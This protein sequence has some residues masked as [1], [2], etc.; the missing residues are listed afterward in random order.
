MPV[1]KSVPLILIVATLLMMVFFS[2][3]LLYSKGISEEEIYILDR[4]KTF[5]IVYPKGEDEPLIDPFVASDELS[6]LILE[7]LFEGLYRVEHETGNAVQAI[8]EHVEV[9]EDGLTWTFDIY[10]DATF[11]NGDPITAK[12][13]V[14]SWLHLLESSSP[15]AQKSYLVSLFDVIKGAK[16]YR[17]GDGK[18]SDVGIHEKSK[19][20]LEVLLNNK[21]PYLSSLLTNVTF[22]AIHPDTYKQRNQNLI[23]SG[24]YTLSNLSKEEILLEKNTNYREA[25][26][27]NN[28]YVEIL[29]RDDLEAIESY[30]NKE[31]HWLLSY[32][33]P[34]LLRTRSDLH[35]SKIYATGFFY[36]SAKDGPYSD[37]R[38][39]KAISLITPWDEIRNNSGQLFPSATLIP[40][41]G[42]ILKKTKVVTTDSQEEAKRLLNL[43][44]FSSF[45]DL[46]PL[47]MA[48][49]RGAPIQ[50][51]AMSLALSWSNTLTIPVIVD[52]VPLSLYTRYPRENPYD[53]SYITWVADFNDP[54]AFLPLFGSSSSYNIANYSNKE[55][56]TLLEKAVNSNNEEERKIAIEA[57]EATLLE[58]AIIFPIHSGF[59]IHIV[60]SEVV[61]GWYDNTINIHPLRSLELIER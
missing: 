31:A 38:V 23:F 26:S 29:I 6:L 55:Y 39:R 14:D 59:S 49:H 48:I 42:S 44:G 27:V 10:N 46:P 19:F 20:T 4:D 33:P 9:S 3:S 28:D 15:R 60:D 34:Q 41:S 8:A 21:A 1:K 52:T 16:E 37:A 53:V 30:L 5:V 17:T 57:A 2:S 24:A 35:L 54:F 12:V 36:F 18:R 40:S 22:A 51:T 25:S 45:N 43:A 61:K 11:S 58:E 50:E 56:D 7:G 32:V 47:N 13:F